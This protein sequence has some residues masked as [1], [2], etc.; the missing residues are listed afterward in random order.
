MAGK[1]E[2]LLDRSFPHTVQYYL[3]CIS[4]CKEL[5]LMEVDD[6]KHVTK[7]A[8][9]FSARESGEPARPEEQCPHH[10]GPLDHCRSLR[11]LCGDAIGD[12]LEDFA[13][14]AGRQ[15]HV[16]AANVHPRLRFL[17]QLHDPGRP[18]PRPVSGHRT[19]HGQSQN[20]QVKTLNTKLN[21]LV[22]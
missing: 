5:L 19:A 8:L 20:E 1:K 9:V 15:R 21:E 2:V 11:V 17:P 16:Q 13:A 22:S 10:G 18:Q 3:S 6:I 7:N 12:C 14:V 4:Y